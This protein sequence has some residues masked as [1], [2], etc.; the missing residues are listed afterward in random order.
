MEWGNGFFCFEMLLVSCEF[1]THCLPLHC[2][3]WA[4][5]IPTQML[6]ILNAKWWTFIMPILLLYFPHQYFPLLFSKDPVTNHTVFGLKA[7]P[8]KWVWLHPSFEV[9]WEVSWT[10]VDGPLKEAVE[11]WCWGHLYL[12]DSALWQVILHFVIFVIN[13]IPIF[14]NR[15]VDLKIEMFILISFDFLSSM[16]HKRRSVQGMRMLLLFSIKWKWMVTNI[17]FRIIW[18][19]IIAEQ[20]KSSWSWSWF[21]FI[22]WIKAAWTFF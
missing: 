22:V 6:L 16:E 17:L 12:W 2:T 14:I 1:M 21:S 11:R 18:T 3:H 19:H 20:N 8:P 5:D 13:H 7:L 9:L 10:W 15:I 4:P